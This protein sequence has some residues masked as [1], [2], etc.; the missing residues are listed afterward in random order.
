MAAPSVKATKKGQNTIASVS[1]RI[2]AHRDTCELLGGGKLSVKNSPFGGNKIS[3][4]TGGTEG[5]TRC[6]HT[7]KQTIC[8]KA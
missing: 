2:S 7:K 6:T 4:C 8:G 5:G 1:D 3:T